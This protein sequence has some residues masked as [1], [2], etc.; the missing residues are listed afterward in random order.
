MTDSQVSS[1]VILLSSD[2]EPKLMTS[3][4]DQPFGMQPLAGCGY[5]LGWS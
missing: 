1:S 2:I 3:D 4:R 5:H